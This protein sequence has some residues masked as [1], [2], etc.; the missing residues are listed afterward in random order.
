MKNTL[1]LIALLILSC[2]IS[3]STQSQSTTYTYPLGSSFNALEAGAPP[4]VQIPNNDGLTGEF[5][6]RPIPVS[7]CEQGGNAKGYYFEDDA[8]LQFNVPDGFIDDGTYSLSMIFH[9][10]EFIDPPPWVRI[11]SFTHDD[12]HGIYIYLSNPPDNGTLDFWPYSQVGAENFFNTNDYYQLMLIRDAEGMVKVYINGEE[13]ASYDDSGTGEYIPQI[14]KDY[15]IFFRDHP[16]VLANEASP[17]FV[18]N[19]VLSDNPWTQQQVEARWE[20]FCGDL[21]SLDEIPALEIKIYPN[22]VLNKLNIDLP[23][24][25]AKAELTVYDITGK[26][27]L[28][29]SAEDYKSQ[30]DVSALHP[31]LY[32]LKIKIDDL[33]RMS[34][35]TKE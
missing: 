25:H 6:N 21:L 5:V 3:I 1:Y 31:G 14:G 17:G 29:A 13:F 7:T 27:I 35:F 22:P 11:L 28:T 26:L 15:L 34:R 12:D 20:E 23:E 16:S 19:I 30:L 4:L 8:G 24:P 9:F 32:I 10:D 18:S 33:V 2:G